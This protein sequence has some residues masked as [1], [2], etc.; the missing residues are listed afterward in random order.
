MAPLPRKV[1]RRA[2]LKRLLG[3]DFDPHGAGQQ[4]VKEL[5]AAEGGSWTGKELKARFGFSS[6]ALHSRRKDHRI[7]FW[8]DRRHG[9]RYPTWQFDPAGAL[10]PGIQEILQ[11][12]NSPDQW[13]I[14]RY[15]LTTRDQ[16]GGRRPLDLLR[17]GQTAQVVQHA[18]R[19]AE[20][21][22]W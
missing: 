8:R 14:M 6:A 12:F 11:T 18:K 10:L 2:E 19:H 15:F 16:L 4:L 21:S 3:Q 22:T 9:F 5:Q 13:R 1:L 17:D 20:E 7:G